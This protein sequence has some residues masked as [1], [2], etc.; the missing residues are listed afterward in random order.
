MSIYNKK[1]FGVICKLAGPIILAQLA[2]TG[3]T[4]AEVIMAGHFK[5]G[6]IS[7]AGVGIGV[8]IWLPAIL[9]AQGLLSILTPLISNLNGA[10]Q[11]DK[12]R[13]YTRTGLILA[14]LLSILLMFVLYHSDKIIAWRS[15]ESEPIDPEMMA[16]AVNFLR[17]IMWGVPGMLYYLVYRFQCE[18]L[19][20]TKPI[21][22][23]MIMALIINIPINYIFIYGKL[24]LPAM[25]GVGCGVAAAITFWVMFFLMKMVTLTLHSQ[26][27][28]RKSTTKFTLDFNLIRLIVKLG[29]PLGFAYLFEVSLFS[30][31]A[32]LIAPLGKEVVAAHQ[33]IFQISSITFAIPLSI[34]IATSIRIGYL[35]GKKEEFAAK[36]SANTSLI[37]SFISA[38]LI[39][40]ILIFGKSLI[41][42]GFSTNPFITNIALHII[43]LLAMYQ[44][45]DYLQVTSSNV[46]RA[47]KDTRSILYITF[48]SYWIIGL[49]VGYTLSLT[50]LII[51][52][53][54]VY[55]FWIG[56]NIGLLFSCILLYVRLRYVQKK[57]PLG[58]S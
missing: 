32:L 43:I 49:P 45:F 10:S 58:L 36:E 52:A 23:I 42:S 57:Y 39:A 44:V 34:G 17:A 7:L 9:F 54:G 25:G 31:V 48:I 33:I 27:D 56:F 14:T 13:Q 37:T 41:I 24:G 15:T 51:P 40:S 2:Q 50:N 55:G 38:L 53:I 30:L 5:D 8:S 29:L 11:R 12:I 20:N 1:E 3:I 35:L 46:L 28:I 16:M 22:L 21:M 6:G 19:S 18:G 4:L 26:K 47:Y